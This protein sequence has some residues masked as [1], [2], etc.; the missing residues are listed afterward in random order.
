MAL[1]EERRWLLVSGVLLLAFSITVSGEQSP[2]KPPRPPLPLGATF[3]SS[4]IGISSWNVKLKDPTAQA[5]G[6][7]DLTLAFLTMRTHREWETTHFLPRPTNTFALFD[8]TAVT[9]KGWME[10]VTPITAS[11]FFGVRLDLYGNAGDSRTGAVWG[12]TQPYWSNRFLGKDSPVSPHSLWLRNNKNDM[13]YTLGVFSPLYQSDAVFKGQPN[14]TLSGSSHLPLFGFHL[15]KRHYNPTTTYF[16]PQA[17]YEGFV[18]ALAEDSPYATALLGGTYGWHGRKERVD[19]SLSWVQN[20]RKTA[21]LI[22]PPNQGSGLTWSAPGGLVGKQRQVSVG[23]DGSWNLHRN[24]KVW[25]ALAYSDYEPGNG[26]SDANGFLLSVGGVTKVLQGDLFVDLF[27]VDPD[28]DP[29][30]LPMPRPIG[31]SEPAMFYDVPFPTRYPNH[32]FL[33]DS[34]KYPHNRQGVKMQWDFPLVGIRSFGILSLHF[35]HLRQKNASKASNL[36]RP[37]FIEPLFAA[38]MATGTAKKGRINNWGIS[39]R[40]D[41]PENRRLMLGFHEYRFDRHAADANRIDTKARFALFSFGFPLRYKLETKVY[42]DLG[43]AAA[44]GD[45]KWLSV[46]KNLDFIQHGPFL[47]LSYHFTHSPNVLKSISLTVRQLWQHDKAAT[48]GDWLATQIALEGR[49]DF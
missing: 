41:L 23:I 42:L 6:A 32:Y 13:L 29:F 17:M 18:G 22:A 8:E 39:L 21:G 16:K 7:F 20:F 10:I 12:V 26:A 28:Y 48:M 30:I 49:W 45:G 9:A 33:H 2:T 4:H 11:K 3:Y 36:T 19:L 40:Y 37:G 35:G 46:A 14:P 38:G 1:G 5:Q 15:V 47:R 31:F 24:S 27:S 34:H 43:Y 25:L 44:S